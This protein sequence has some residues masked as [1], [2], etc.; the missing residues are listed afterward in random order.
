MIRITTDSA[1]TLDLDW[2]LLVSAEHESLPADLNQTN[3]QLNGKLACIW[4]RKEFAGNYCRTLSLRQLSEITPVNLLLTGVGP[5]DE[6]SAERLRRSLITSLRKINEQ[7]DLRIG[8]RF[9]DH[10][11]TAW[12]ATT[13]TELV[14]DCVTVAAVDAGIHKQKPSRFDFTDVQIAVDQP[15]TNIDDYI[16]SGR[17]IGSAVA[18]TR[19]MVNCS[20]SHMTP[21]R[22][23]EEAGQLAEQRDLEFQVLGAA[24]LTRENMN[25]MLAVAQGSHRTP[26]LVRLSW[27]GNPDCTDEIA[28]A[29][30]GVTFDSGGLSIKPAESMVAMKS[31]MA[32]AATVMEAVGAAAS[33]RL[34]VNVTAWLGLVENMIS[35]Q[36]YR[37][38]DVIT[39]RTGTTIE[40]QNTDAEGRLV[41]ADVLAYA[42]D[43]GTTH[44]IDLATLTGAC[45]VA[46]GK[47]ITGLFAGCEE[48]SGRIQQAASNTGENVW[49]MPMHA[50]F[51][52]LL[53]SDVADCRN[54]GPRWG[55]AVTAACFLRKFVGTTPWVHLDIAGPSW[56]DTS[57]DWRDS[58][59]TG[60]MVRTLIRLLRQWP[61]ESPPGRC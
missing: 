5:T 52:E 30:K 61:V 19:C 34:P 57:T 10:L 55:G 32:G 45:V 17:I 3:R 54:I 20:P 42:I 1:V 37:P 50:H 21:E 15:P 46:L 23:V 13:L 35:G 22:M 14:A 24:D 8:V 2:L 7:P 33:L 59:G 26:S 44:L 31:D 43:H 53:K 4:N 27:R 6:L 9:A 12:S 18:R 36:S 16:E 39:A 40:V 58:G 41:L 48:L 38:G 47:E 28:L 60:A 56:A 25:A 11:T 49:P 51:D 29:G